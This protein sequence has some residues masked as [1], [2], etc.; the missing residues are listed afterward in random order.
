MITD[1][2]DAHLM[3]QC[4]HVGAEG[5]LR[6]DIPDNSVAENVTTVAQQ[7][8]TMTENSGTH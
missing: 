1:S 6:E 2:H 3:T 8:K 4:K 5:P 7:S